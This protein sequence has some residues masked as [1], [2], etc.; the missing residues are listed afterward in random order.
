MPVTVRD[1]TLQQKDQF[2]HSKY[3]EN[4]CDLLSENPTNLHYLVFEK[5]ALKYMG[6]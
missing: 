3:W 2:V 1:T 6:K 4:K 5:T